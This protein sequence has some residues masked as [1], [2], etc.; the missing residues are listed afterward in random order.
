MEEELGQLINLRRES[1]EREQIGRREVRKETLKVMMLELAENTDHGGDDD[2]AGNDCRL[3][4]HC[5]RSCDQKK[6]C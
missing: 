5:R 4:E 2:D 6:N 3:E 1:K